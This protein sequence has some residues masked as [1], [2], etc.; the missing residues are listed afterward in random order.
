[1]QSAYLQHS[2]EPDEVLS[3][4]AYLEDADK[5][6]AVDTSPLLLTFLLMSLAGT[7][8][9]LA[10]ASAAWGSRSRRRDQAT[11]NGSAGTALPAAPPNLAPSPLH[12]VGAGL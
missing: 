2:L 3:L 9:A 6:A 7:M 5:W 4:V 11:P 8:L 10:A 12:R 1:M